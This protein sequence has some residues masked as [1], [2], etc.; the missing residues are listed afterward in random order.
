MASFLRDGA[1]ISE[2]KVDC[3]LAGPGG[4]LLAAIRNLP[5]E[6]KK[7]EFG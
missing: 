4:G 1:R 2:K 5:Q 3:A 6:V 7:G